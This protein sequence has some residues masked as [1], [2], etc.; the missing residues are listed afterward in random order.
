MNKCVKII[1]SLCLSL[2][3]V[4]SGIFVFCANESGLSDPNGLHIKSLNDFLVFADDCRLDS[5][6]EDLTVYL[7]VDLDLSDTEFDGV[8]TFS[9]TFEGNDHIIEGLSIKKDG[10][11]QGLFRYLTQTAHVKDLVVRGDVSPAGSGKYVGGIAGSNAGIIENCIFQGE[12]SGTDYVGGIAGTNVVTG[13][14]DTCNVSGN[15]YGN[16]FVGG[17]TGENYGTVRGSVNTSEVNVT[18]KQ[19]TVDLS[20]ITLE[21]LKD[22][23][24]VNTVTDIGGIAGT[25]SGVIKESNNLG[26]VGYLRMGYNIGGIAGSQLGYIVDCSNFAK[27]YG[28][29]DVGGI[30]GQVEPSSEIEYS[31]DTL[32][33]L[34]QKLST[35]YD[36]FHHIPDSVDDSNSYLSGQFEILGEQLTVIED[37]VEVL[38]PEDGSRSDP[39]TIV[40]AANS[41]GGSMN[42]IYK[43]LS[44]IYKSAEG[45]ANSMYSDAQKI[46]EQIDS[47]VALLCDPTGTFGIGFRDISDE[48]TEDNLIGKIEDSANYGSISGDINAGGIVGTV[49]WEND[50]DAEDD[51]EISGEISMNFQGEVRAVILNCKNNALVSVSKRNAGGIAGYMTFGLVKDSINAGKIDASA[52]EYVGGIVGDSTGFIRGNSSKCELS[53]S[54]N[55]GGI[56][57][58]AVTVTDCISMVDISDATEK[59]GAII[60]VDGNA[61]LSE[62]EGEVEDNYYL[63]VHENLGGIDG[64]DYDG[65]AVSLDEEEFMELP[66]LNDIFTRS[67]V[68]FMGENG[69]SETVF[70]PTGERLA[71]AQIPAVPAKNGCNGEWENLETTDLSNI[72]FDLIFYPVYTSY[73]VSVQSRLTRYDGKPILIA[74]GN[75]PDM[76]YFELEKITEM[77]VVGEKEKA[78]EGWVIPNFAEEKTQL[79]LSMPRGCST[80]AVKILV[81]DEDGKWNDTPFTVSSSYVVFSVDGSD[82]EFC[83]VSVPASVKWWVYVI[84]GVGVAAVAAGIVILIKKKSK[85]KK[86]SEGDTD[87]EEIV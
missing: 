3:L 72:Y 59:T 26:T 18:E 29:K 82:E 74:Q 14:I 43:T 78:V 17:V 12:V 51:W 46:S 79:R 35:T 31:T 38:F 53:G 50:M 55:V 2:C 66:D 32:Q 9:G 64:I 44:V 1:I 57:G 39:D 87:I 25:N 83:V 30:V 80:D 67:T 27:I 77:P 33:S 71:A 86:K 8:P 76:D 49:A 56:A 28:R 69:I 60:G 5:Y 84:G 16:H 24:S 81:K 45:T 75:F 4:A 62:D 20:D 40:A 73:Q 54:I 36:L 10:S 42:S 19:N 61:V 85:A 68:T 70:V 37:F 41:L 52:A 23:E 58:R 47:M 15:V 65:A 48:D 22:S 7:D 34:Q 21:S 11:A 6:S 13:I 63:V